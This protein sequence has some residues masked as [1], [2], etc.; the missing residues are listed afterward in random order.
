MSPLEAARVYGRTFMKMRYPILTVAAVLAH[1]ERTGAL[2]LA[3]GIETDE[4]LEQARALGATLG[5]GFRF[6]RPDAPRLPKPAWIRARAPSARESEATRLL[7]RTHGLTT[8]C[9]EAQCPN[10]AECWGKRHATMMIMGPVCTRACAFCDIM[11]CSEVESHGFRDLCFGNF[12]K[13][14][15]PF[16]HCIDCVCVGF[17]AAHTVCNLYCR[18]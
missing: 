5:Q 12:Y 1:R 7:L 10:L 17:A 13:P 18:G 11:R 16:A 14:R 8:V 3:E 9:E 4:H 2:V 15:N 6:G